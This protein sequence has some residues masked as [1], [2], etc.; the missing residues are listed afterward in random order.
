MARPLI[1]AHSLFGP[2]K[3]GSILQRAG[4]TAP[5][6]LLASVGRVRV[7][8]SL[9][10]R[11]SLGRV[12]EDLGTTLLDL[13]C[14]DPD[15][16]GDI[17][18]VLIYDP[19]DE[20]ELPRQ[21]L[22][23]G[24]GLH[25]PGE[26]AR[27]LADLG[28][29]GAAGLI[30][31]GPAPLDD[32]VRAAAHASGV[33]LLTLTRGA[34]WSQLAAMLRTL[35]AE[36]EV[37]TAGTETLGGMP[38]GDLFALANAIAAMLDAPVTIEDRSSRVL[39]FS[40]RQ[41]EADPSRVQTI[42]GRQVPE[43]VTHILEERGDF[44][45]VY[46]SAAPVF[47]ERI[48]GLDET[49]LHRAAV[50]VRAGEE[51]LGSIWAAIR[52]PLSEERSQALLEASKLVALHM[53]H[54]RASSDVERRLRADQLGTALGG[55]PEAADA[56][57]RLG[58]ADQP[59]VVLA[60]TVLDPAADATGE[61]ST[62][63]HAELVAERKGVADAFAMH[64]SAVHPRAVA[65]LV[66][67]VAYG[68]LPVQRGRDDG[69]YRATRIAADFLSRIG[70]RV[71]AVIGVGPLAA[72]GAA[73]AR[74]RAG[75]DR[76]LR[77]LRA[78][79]GTRRVAGLAE[80]RIEAVLLD[81]ADLMAAR[82]DPPSGPV[83]RLVAYDAKHRS[84]LVDTLRAWLDAF[85]DV[86]AASAAMYVHPNTF[87]YRLRRVAEVGGLDLDDPRVRFGAMLELNLMTTVRRP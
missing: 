75:A 57:R 32:Q 87:R 34:S 66:G 54:Q 60:L 9:R 73:I 55:G 61:T 83:A 63:R 64:L 44:Q 38:A 62:A 24:I 67:D 78:G 3:S 49:A 8:V 29:H 35:I 51:I 39:A 37:D 42:L 68:V 71:C 1:A 5:C 40:G 7:V 6:R 58:L 18:G 84:L 50:A 47:L 48:P 46:R 45:R 33:A 27:L 69:E 11:A 26:I 65:A 80:V 56:I 2:T 25:E 28:R 74:S 14:G 36:G 59:G 23:L 19:L 86:A 20:P 70:P 12:L 53:L 10:P 82:D 15:R 81:L 85:G 4:R 76:A 41:D 43:E 79:D 52:E 13:A 30:V 17:G 22:V 77:V 72:E 21:A 31:R 16:A